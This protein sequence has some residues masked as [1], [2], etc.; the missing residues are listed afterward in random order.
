VIAASADDLEEVHHRPALR[1]RGERIPIVELGAILGRSV[2]MTDPIRAIVVGENGRRVALAVSGWEGDQDVVVKPL[3]ELLEAERLFAG[4]CLLESGELTLVLNPATVTAQALD[5]DLRAG[6]RFRQRPGVA[7]QRRGQ[8][9]LF[10]EDSAVTRSMILRVLSELGYQ[11]TVARDG[12]EA[13]EL[14]EERG[15]DLVLTDLDMPVMNG[16]ELVRRV[17]GSEAWRRLPVLVLSTREGEADRRRALDAGA[18]DYLLKGEGWEATLREAL[19]RK[20]ELPS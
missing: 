5:A 18:D 7:A 9:I 10:A 15:A 19:R 11:V 20:L 1:A 12:R 3:G 17:R 4:A 13:L 16:D 8:R 2:P 6:W 14:L